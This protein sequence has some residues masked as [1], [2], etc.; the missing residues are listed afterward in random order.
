MDISKC[1]PEFTVVINE[2]ARTEMENQE[3]MED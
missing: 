1:V 2:V 3:T